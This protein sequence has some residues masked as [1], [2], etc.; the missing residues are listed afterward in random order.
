MRVRKF[1]DDRER[2]TTA[3]SLAVSTEGL[4]LE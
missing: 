3:C 4:E 1:F 2:A